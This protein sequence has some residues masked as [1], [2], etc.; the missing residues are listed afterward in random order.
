MS[1]IVKNITKKYGDKVVVED[2]SFSIEKPGVYALLGTN[3]AGKTTS[4]RIILGMLSK[5]KGEVLWK[6]NP[7]DTV[8]ANVGYLAEERGLYPKYSLLDQLLY[9][10][11]L[12]NVPKKTAM[13]RI[14]YWSERLSVNEYLFPPKV[15]GKTVKANKADQLSKGNQQ[16]LQLMAALISDPELIILD[17]P[18]SGLD[19]V[20]TELFK[21]II[22]EEIAKDKYLIMSSH[23]MPVI[24]EFCSDITILDKGKVVLSGNLNEVKKSYG[25]VNLFVKSDVE[26]ASYIDSF[27]IEITNKTPGE[28]QLKVL[29]EEQAMAFLTKLIQDKIPIVK[30]ELREPSLHEIFIE[31]VGDVHEEK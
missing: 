23:Q 4:L 19:P 8:N 16:K 27:G 9:F 29:G 21:G 1:L 28:Y 11:K 30:F 15:K 10:A 12:R 26:I 2:L 25:R 5:D 3:G 20:N 17:E 6:G 14:E 18:L 24:E 31:K 7:L 22:R 13:S